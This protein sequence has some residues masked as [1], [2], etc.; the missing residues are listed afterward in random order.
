MDRIEDLV[1]DVVERTMAD[2]EIKEL[3]LQQW[4]SPRVNIVKNE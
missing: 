2:P 1:C 3:I 4:H